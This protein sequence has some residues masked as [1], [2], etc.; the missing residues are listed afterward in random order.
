MVLGI[1]PGLQR[2]GWG[3][4]IVENNTLKYV[5]H[6]VI[7]T[8]S[9]ADLGIRL[10][11]IYEGLWQVLQTYQPNEAAVEETFVNQNPLTTLRLG[12]AR[13][14]ALCT[15][16]V[17]GIN[18]YEYSANKVKKSVVG[19]GHA[20]KNQVMTMVKMLLPALKEE[21]SPDSS[22]ALAIAICHSNH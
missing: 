16:A 10:K 19:A 22:D 17:F 7:K 5:S 9:N 13:G 2:T 4:V 8:D 12:M 14:V 6:G 18:V 15:P 1:D 11:E 21:I 20:D 3:I